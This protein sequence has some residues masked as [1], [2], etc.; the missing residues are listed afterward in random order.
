MDAEVIE[1]PIGVNVHVIIRAA[2]KDGV[3]LRIE[4]YLKSYAREGYGTF[5]TQKPVFKEPEWGTNFEPCWEARLT[6][7][8]SCD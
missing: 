4:K 3:E 1:Q 7:Y 8:G 2:T 6:R 5:V